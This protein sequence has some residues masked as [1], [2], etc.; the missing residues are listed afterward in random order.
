[1]GLSR[2]NACFFTPF[3][4]CHLGMVKSERRIW[5]DMGEEAKRQQGLLSIYNHRESENHRMAWVG[6]D[7]KDHLI[8]T[9]SV[10]YP[11]LSMFLPEVPFQAQITQCHPWWFYHKA[12]KQEKQDTMP[13]VQNKEADTEEHIAKDCMLSPQWVPASLFCS[14]QA[15]IV[16]PGSCPSF[17]R[18]STGED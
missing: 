3:F 10:N 5:K 2:S 9:P 8:L 4:F 18:H 16:L 13:S 6:S 15:G 17:E 1:M 11:I 7:L 12:D 14:S